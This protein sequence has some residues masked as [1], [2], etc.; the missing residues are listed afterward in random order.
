MK[1]SERAAPIA[2]LPIHFRHVQS[3]VLVGNQPVERSAAGV[4]RGDKC[5]G[6]V[7]HY[8][9]QQG[10]RDCV[11]VDTKPR[12]A[13]DFSVTRLPLSQAGDAKRRENRR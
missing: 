6:D 4:G 10:R 2:D 1:P 13:E 8:R 9:V 3:L 12:L 7:H 5:L 11:V